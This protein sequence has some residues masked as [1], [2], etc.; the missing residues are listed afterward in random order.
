VTSVVPV[1]ARARTRVT[2]V[3]VLNGLLFASWV[4]RI[5]AVRD[6]L[7]LSH[8]DIGLVLLT[9]SLGAVIALP[10]TGLV[11][12][13][14]GAATTIRVAVTVCASGLVVAGFAGG[15]GMLVGGLFLMGLG[16]G[17]WDV[18]MNVEGARVERR[19]GRAVMPH[20]HGAW[21]VGSVVGALG[22][23]LVNY[24]GVPTA[25]HLTVVAVGAV[26]AGM[27]ACGGFLP[28]EQRVSGRLEPA[29][30][31]GD[32]SGASGRPHTGHRHPLRA[33]LEPR[34]LAIGL[35]VLTFAFTEGTANDWLALALIDGYGVAN[36][37][38][39]LTFA[40]FTGAMMTGRFL[41]TV[42]LDR[43]GRVRVLQ[44]SVLL[45]IAGL[46]LVVTGGSPAVAMAGSIAWGLGASLGWPVGVSAASDDPAHAAARV[47][48]VSSV[49]YGAF[50][51]GPPL[52]G[53]VAQRSDVVHAL[54]LVLGALVLALLL[55][56]AARERGAPLDA[57]A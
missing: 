20:F 45:A 39:V 38:G 4:S 46:L 18:A 55:T 56:S 29:R 52:V 1:V 34:T 21:S 53:F 16:T 5:P 32:A 41:G 24:A 57:C 30:V 47:S 8:R 50:L 12:L 17:A 3:F 43:F 33:W 11:V 37:V 19:L 6:A 48:V 27:V 31:P 2:L 44:S 36:A 25:V 9:I 49:G 42:L 51:A 22:G 15:V 26:V 13:R 7:E 23:A 10:S 54:W 14:L 40:L 35:L 28:V